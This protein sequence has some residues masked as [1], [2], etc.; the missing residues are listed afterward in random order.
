MNFLKSCLNQARSSLTTPAL[1]SHATVYISKVSSINSFVLC[2]SLRVSHLFAF[3]LKSST[4]FSLHCT[5]VDFGSFNVTIISSKAFIADCSLNVHVDFLV[6]FFTSSLVH[7]ASVSKSDTIVCLLPFMLLSNIRFT[8]FSTSS[9]V[10]F[11]AFATYSNFLGFNRPLTYNLFA[12]GHAATLT[13]ANTQPKAPHIHG[14]SSHTSH[15]F[16]ISKVAHS[17]APTNTH[18]NTLDSF[19]YCTA[20][21]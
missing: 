12:N 4:S 9:P 11:S 2:I 19:G 21:V 18:F 3:I 10:S 6:M 20:I 14:F 8:I 16:A 5:F 7:A 15:W 13:Q 1:A 17:V